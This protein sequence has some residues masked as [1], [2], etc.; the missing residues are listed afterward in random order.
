MCKHLDDDSGLFVMPQESDYLLP[1]KAYMVLKWVGLVLCPALA[2]LIGTLGPAW[3]I[4]EVDRVVLTVNAVG[5]FIGA[6]IGAS[7]LNAGRS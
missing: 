7:Q 5:L 2:T 4:A 3:G 6:V 1:D